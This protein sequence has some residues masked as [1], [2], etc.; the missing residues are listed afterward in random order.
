MAIFFSFS[1]SDSHHK[2]IRWKFVTH[3][4]IDGYSRLI[5]FLKCST[6]NRSLTLY[7]LF[8]EA[9]HNYH[10]PSRVRTDQGG[11]N[12]LVAQHMLEHR[13][14]ERR[15]FITGSSVHNNRIERLWRDLH[16]GVTLLYYRLFYYL[17]QYNLLDP[18]NEQHLYALHY[19]FA[20]RIN[21]SITEFKNAWN[22]HHIRTAHHKSPY[23]LFTAGLLLL[24]HS[25]ITAID[26]FDDVDDMYGVDRDDPEPIDTDGTVVV[27]NLSFQ[28]A[29]GDL[30]RLRAIVN[31]LA[32][33]HNY[34]IDL[35]E[36]TLHF[37][38]SL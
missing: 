24:Q 22:H 18:L 7:N 36:Q 31:P 11:E 35:Y 14:S 5:V 20:A 6:N 29:G 32:G 4:G 30:Q 2:L 1:V 21:K 3:G 8:L 10:L 12:V 9:V 27:S 37:I 16:Q 33:S 38:Q 28:L 25:D 19:V 26:F 23:Q 17:E 15:S 34:G 13:G